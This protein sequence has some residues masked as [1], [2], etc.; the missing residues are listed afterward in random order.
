[1]SPASFALA[2]DGVAAGRWGSTG[3]NSERETTLASEADAKAEAR[4]QLDFLGGPLALDE[5]QLPGRWGW[6][7]G[8]VITVTA[9][10]LNYEHGCDVF[11]LAANDDLA[12]GTSTVSVLRR[13]V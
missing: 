13:L 9:E 8:T 11:V 7:L 10:R 5:H 12:A 3:R 6:A 1:M 2:A 4:R